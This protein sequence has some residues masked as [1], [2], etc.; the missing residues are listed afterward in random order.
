[1]ENRR[2]F[3]ENLQSLYQDI[4]RMGTLAEGPIRKALK[5]LSIGNIELAKQMTKIG[6]SMVHD[7]I[8]AIVEHVVEET[9]SVAESE[10][11]VDILHSHLYKELLQI[12]ESHPEKLNQGVNLLFLKRFF[13]HL[14][15]HVTE[16][17]EWVSYA[18]QGDT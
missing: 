14:E 8:S 9:R 2:H 18:K 1:M 3:H 6:I 13:E 16:V 12:L 7:S 10:K 5:S 17:R 11:Q 15:D 4:L